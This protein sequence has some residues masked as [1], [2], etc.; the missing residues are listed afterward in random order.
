MAVPGTDTDMLGEHSDDT[1][2][3]T[4]LNLGCLAEIVG[5]MISMITDNIRKLGD[6]I[7]EQEARF[8][9]LIRFLT[10]DVI[11]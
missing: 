2:N 10:N 3:L 7:V 9:S 8:G 6:G 11:T 5:A 1:M 4:V